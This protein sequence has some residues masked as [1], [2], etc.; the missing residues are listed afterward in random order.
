[1][2][3]RKK[4]GPGNRVSRRNEDAWGDY[5]EHAGTQLSPQS[6]SMAEEAYIARMGGIP[7][8]PT[9]EE[10]PDHYVFADKRNV[11]PGE[12]Q[13]YYVGSGPGMEE[14]YDWFDDYADLHDPDMMMTLPFLLV[15]IR[16]TLEI[17]VLSPRLNAW[18]KERNPRSN[19]LSW[20]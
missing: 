17:I 8:P 18:V 19:L 10:V 2:F 5:I 7:F 1:M 13:T 3:G 6:L 16:P 12:A 20:F 15:L 11:M 14:S 9:L 4:E